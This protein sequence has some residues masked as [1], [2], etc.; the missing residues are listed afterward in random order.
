MIILKKF[1]IFS[2]F[3]AVCLLCG[4]NNDKPVV[5]TENTT[6]IVTEAPVVTTEETVKHTEVSDLFSGCKTWKLLVGD[7]EL[8]SDTYFI[9]DSAISGRVEVST[10][11]DNYNMMSFVYCGTEEYMR[12]DF[13]NCTSLCIKNLV[14]DNDK[15]DG[16]RFSDDESVGCSFEQCADI[17]PDIYFAKK[18]K[19]SESQG[20]IC[21]CCRP[22]YELDV[23]DE[24]IV[25]D[26]Q[27]A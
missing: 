16:L 24:P 10:E 4:C 20:A 27:S 3:F 1:G 21:N 19:V 13:D 5:V 17:D 8:I 15:I 6:A 18:E 9:F 23:P 22:T 2:L 26:G 7:D 12:F 14:P 25:S 11:D